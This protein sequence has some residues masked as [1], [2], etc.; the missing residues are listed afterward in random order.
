M[1]I[2]TVLL[3]TQTSVT[4]SL[5]VANVG[6]LSLHSD[7]DINKALT[8]TNSIDMIPVKAIVETMHIANTR[9]NKGADRG[10]DVS[11]TVLLVQHSQLKI[12]TLYQIL[13]TLI[14][15]Y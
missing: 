13:I 3:T 5:V 4:T 1:N 7:N 15:P 10:A 11:Y 2:N 6:P 8:T 14:T 9:G 12:A